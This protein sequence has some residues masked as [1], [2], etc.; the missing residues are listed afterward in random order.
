VFVDNQLH[1]GT[2]GG[3]AATTPSLPVASSSV[4]CAALPAAVLPCV[5]PCQLPDEPHRQLPPWPPSPRHACDTVTHTML[6]VTALQLSA[7]GQIICKR[8]A[9]SGCRARS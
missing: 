2:R 8:L 4:R 3:S 7:A 6:Y 9:S 1:S 5:L